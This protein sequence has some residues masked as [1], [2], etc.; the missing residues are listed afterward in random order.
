[1]DVAASRREPAFDHGRFGIDTSP[2]AGHE[3]TELTAR[4]LMDRLDAELIGNASI[5]MGPTERPDAFEVLS[6][7]ELQLAV[8]IETM[9]REG[10]ELTVGT[11]VVVTRQID[12]T[13]H[14]PVERV[15][16]DGP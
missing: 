5:E 10:F 7:G 13:T 2:L 14:E 12:G 8:P 15:A 3:G 1:V 4:M 16:L 9:R 6:R 11:S